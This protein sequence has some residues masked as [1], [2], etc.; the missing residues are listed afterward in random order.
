M[1]NNFFFKLRCLIFPNRCV[2]C[3]EICSH[4]YF[5]N[6]CS[7]KLK[8]FN[9]KLCLKCGAP[10]KYCTCKYYFYYFDKVT[11]AFPNEGPAQESFYRFKFYGAA[12]SADFFV[13]SMCNSIKNDFG[14]IK[15]D[16]ITSV[17][18]QYKKKIARGYNQSELIARKISKL[19]K[20]KYKNLLSQTGPS[21]VQHR[22]SSVSER[23]LNVK[24]I[25][26]V[27]SPEHISGKTVLLIDDIMTTGA[28]LSECARQLKLSGAEEVY[29]ATALKTIRKGKN[30]K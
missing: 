25:F 13:K 6:N 20:I 29:C 12:Y 14:D 15:F 19:L 27:K 28:T 23:F 4:R 18:M 16:Y 17:P 22:L 30:S 8:P 11:S 10:L 3:N 24:D 9:I 5:C 7:E 2:V 21:G 1:L 26:K